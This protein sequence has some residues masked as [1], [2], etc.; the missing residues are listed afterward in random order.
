MP[1]RPV[2]VHG[3]E[4][5]LELRVVEWLAGLLVHQLREPAHVPHHVRLPGEQ[6]DLPLGPAQR[7]PPATRRAGS[8]YRRVHLTTSVHGESA[9]NFPGSGVH[10]LQHRCH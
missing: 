4:D 6:A 7:G 9:Q 8:V 1:S 2:D 5:D 10:C 3:R